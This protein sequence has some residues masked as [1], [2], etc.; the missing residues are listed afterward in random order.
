MARRR[1]E[2]PPPGHSRVIISGG[3]LVPGEL[4]PREQLP[5]LMPRELTLREL[6][7]RALVPS[8]IL[9]KLNLLSG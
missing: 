6:T 8:L 9:G 2:C 3:R 4:M 5:E 7:L 1:F